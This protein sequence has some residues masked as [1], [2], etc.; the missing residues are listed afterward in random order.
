MNS[1][2]ECT[3]KLKRFHFHD[4]DIFGKKVTLWQNDPKDDA[5][6]RQVSDLL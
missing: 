3:E 6:N 1:F 4:N 5:W 2:G